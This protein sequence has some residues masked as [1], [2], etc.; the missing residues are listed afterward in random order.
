MKRKDDYI[1]LQI[2]TH[3]EVFK[4]FRHQAPPVYAFQGRYNRLDLYLD[5][6]KQAHDIAKIAKAKSY[7]VIKITNWKEETLFQTK[8]ITAWEHQQELDSN[9]RAKNV[10]NKIKAIN[11][12]PVWAEIKNPIGASKLRI[13][14]HRGEAEVP[15]FRGSYSHVSVFIT[16]DGKKPKKDMNNDFYFKQYVTKGNKVQT[17]KFME[18]EPFDDIVTTDAG[19]AKS[20]MIAIMN[21]L[22]D[23]KEKI[24]LAN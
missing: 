12:L 18:W 5:T 9:Q 13:F 14:V 8:D 10:A 3:E 15:T 1:Q 20:F 4:S 2:G 16:E 24:R 17:K 11:K 6:K 22:G 21:G 7:R 19:Y 23:V